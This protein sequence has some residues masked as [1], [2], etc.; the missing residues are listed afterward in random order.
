MSDEEMTQMAP[1]LIK[2]FAAQEDNM[3]SKDKIRS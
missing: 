1:G 2:A 3:D